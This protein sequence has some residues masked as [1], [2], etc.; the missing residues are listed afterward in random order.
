M[1]V[2]GGERP[3]DV[4]RLRW[5]SIVLVL[6][7]VPILSACRIDLVLDVVLD[8]DGSALV[9]FTIRAD[10]DVM[11]HV[12]IEDIDLAGISGT[13]WSMTGP[14]SDVN[15][16]SVTL[17]KPV[18]SAEL[19]DDV[20][21]QLDRGRFFREVAFVIDNGLGETSYEF[22]LTI[23]PQVTAADFSDADL[24][25]LL[26]GERFGELTTV[27]EERAGNS[28]DETLHVSARVVMPD[29]VVLEGRNEPLDP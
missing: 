26:D 11:A 17:S 21:G 4:F 18:P 5:H 20:I 19:L 22:E 28:L 14:T 1:V 2:E 24:A 7:L 8:A 16:A 9:D 10:A 12:D 23:D 6:V 15:G 25:E 13:G 3:A 29:E 27:L